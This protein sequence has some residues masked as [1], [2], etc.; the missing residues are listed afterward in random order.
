M[1]TINVEKRESRSSFGWSRNEIKCPICGEWRSGKFLKN[2]IS[3]STDEK[4]KKFVKENTKQVI[5]NV[6]DVEFN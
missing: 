6:L 3:R 2:H 4:H 5:K 1:K